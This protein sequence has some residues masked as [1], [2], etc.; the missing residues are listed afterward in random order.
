VNRYQLPV[1]EV[2]VSYK[3]DNGV[4]DPAGKVPVPVQEITLL[5]AKLFLGMHR[6]L[7]LTDTKYPAGNIQRHQIY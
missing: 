1:Y 4:G 5:I 7:I 3:I 6:I 2:R